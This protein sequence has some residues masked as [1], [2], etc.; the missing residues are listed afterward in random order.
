MIS[1][2]S[3][4]KPKNLWTDAG[5]GGASSATSPTTSTTRPR[6]S[7]G[8][9]RSPTPVRRSPPTSRCSTAPT[10]SAGSS[11][12]CS[13]GS[14]C[15]TRSSVACG[16]T[17]A[18]RSA[19]R[20]PTC[21]CWPTP[22]TRSR[23]AA[24]STPRAR[25]IGD[26]AEACVTALAERERIPFA[27]PLL[28][29]G[30]TA[31]GM[32][33]AVAQRDR[34]VQPA[35]WTSCA[36]WSRPARGRPTVL[37]AV[38]EQTGYL[39]ELHASRRPPG[40]DAGSRTS[41][42]SWRSAGSSRR[43]TP[44]APSPASSSR[45]RWSPTPTRSPTPT[46]RRAGVVTLMTLHT[47]KGLEFPVV[48]LTGLEDGVFPHLRSLGDPA[49]LEEERRLAYVGITRARQRLYLSRAVVRSAW[50]AP[51][52]NP[53]SRFLDE[54]PEGQWGGGGPGVAGGAPP[55]RGRGRRRGRG[56]S[57][58]RGDPGPPP[59]SR[60]TASPEA[61]GGGGAVAAAGGGGG[62]GRVGL[63][64]GRLAPPAAPPPPPPTGWGWRPAPPCPPCGGGGGPPG[65]AAAA[66]GGARGGGAPVGGGGGGGPRIWGTTRPSIGSDRW[67]TPLMK[68]LR[69]IRSGCS[70]RAELDG[71][72]TWSRSDQKATKRVR[73]PAPARR[74]RR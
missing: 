61:F 32:A 10:P 70:S 23:C 19:T 40:R 45:S 46:A 6:S 16:S 64:R 5:D 35:S 52:Y 58:P 51:S 21:G 8:D 27:G 48:F 43:P 9:R 69:A 59:W 53:P 62:G 7:P 49:E 55:G 24:S 31:P 65:A 42:S 56:P 60:A 44:T 41:A 2:N 37:E 18:G 73:Q 14:A 3:G 74:A 30:R 34:G 20:W 17:S 68:T 26:R 12:R 36:P 67:P 33:P 1:R 25:G 11:R 39:A 72:T 50:G 47:A 54:V 57:R 38:L 13:S 22:T 29:A 63:R 15:P 71:I 66:G 28:R 4:R